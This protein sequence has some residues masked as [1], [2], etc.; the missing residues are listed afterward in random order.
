MKSIVFENLD[1]SYPGQAPLFKGLN[2]QLGGATGNGHVTALLGASGSGKTTFLKLMLGVLAPQMGCVRFSPEGAIFS[3]VPQEPVLFEHLSPMDNARY[4]NYASKLKDRFDPVL[5]EHLIE[6][7][8]IRQ[9]LDNRKN[10]T[11]LSGGQKQRLSLLRA[12]SIKPD[13]LLLDE[14]CTGLDADVKLAFLTKL[15]E[16][17]SDLN[18]F[19]VYVTHHVDEATFAGN[20]IAFLVQDK[21]KGN[22]A[23]ISRQTVEEFLKTPPSLDAL[24]IARFPAINLVG[25][26]T[27]GS[28]PGPSATADRYLAVEEKHITITQDGSGVELTRVFSTGQYACYR[29]NSGHVALTFRSTLPEDEIIRVKISGQLDE[30]GE[31]GIYQKTLNLEICPP[32]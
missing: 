12:L 1:F 2:I 27:N 26:K 7:L 11:E 23:N 17:V 24:R 15:H 13:I 10:I 29:D 4:F 20:E 8:E 3:Y 25:I 6:L 30:Y 22:V 5:F 14:P 31:N 19:A 28:I 16:L 9:V 32:L 18:L 21:V